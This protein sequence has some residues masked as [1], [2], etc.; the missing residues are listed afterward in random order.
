MPA[1]KVPAGLPPDRV[2]VYND[3]YDL[4]GQD[5]AD[6]FA[7]SQGVTVT[8]TPAPVTPVTPPAPAPVNLQIVTSPSGRPTVMPAGTTPPVVEIPE[9]RVQLQERPGIEALR[10]S[11]DEIA[12]GAIKARTI[13][14]QKRGMVYDDARKEAEEYVAKAREAPRTIE[15]R[16]QKVP[17]YS[18]L[19]VRGQEL[20]PKLSAG[21]TVLES[22]KPQV[23]ET[24]EQ[25]E[26]RRRFERAKRDAKTRIESEAQAAGKNYDDYVKDLLVGNAVRAGQIAEQQAMEK[27]ASEV[28]MKDIN[29]IKAQ[30]D[31]PYYAALDE[32]KGVPP[33]EVVSRWATNT[34]RGLTQEE[35]YGRLVETRGAATLRNIGGLSRIAVRG[36]EEYLVEPLV[37]GIVAATDPNVSYSD[38]TKMEE[39]AIKAGGGVAVKRGV[40]GVGE[41]AKVETGSFIKDVAQEV[42]TGRSAIDDYLDAGAP[43]GVATIMGL[44]TEFAIPATPIGVVTDVL[45][46]FGAVGRAIPGVARGAEA[47][48]ATRPIAATRRF[49]DALTNIPEAV[50][51]SRFEKELG[52]QG[53]RIGMNVSR[54]M[55]SPGW[56]KTTSEL[57]DMRTTIATKITDELVAAKEIE[58]FIRKGNA[59]VLNKML[60]EGISGDAG[61]LATFADDVAME[62]GVKLDELD[63]YLT[64]INKAETQGRELSGLQKTLWSRITDASKKVAGRN[65]A[66]LASKETPD[67][68]RNTWAALKGVDPGNYQNAGIKA[69]VAE[70]LEKVP[71][72]QYAFVTPRIAVKKSIINTKEFQDK[73]ADA[74]FASESIREVEFAVEKAIRESYKTAGDIAEP[75][76]VTVPRAEGLLPT[77]PRG[78]LE[79][80]ATPEAR[81]LPVLE[82]AQDVRDTVRAILAEMTSPAGNKRVADTF[83]GSSFIGGTQ[84]TLDTAL[85]ARVPVQMRDFIVA[86]KSEIDSLGVITTRG[87]G[88]LQIQN[89]IIKAINENPDGLNGV[90]LERMSNNIDRLGKSEDVALPMSVNT[91]SAQEAVETIVRNFF[92]E[93]NIASLSVTNAN[94]IIKS[95]VKDAVRNGQAPLDATINAIRLVREQIPELAKAGRRGT[96]LARGQDD[97]VSACLDY[98][99]KEEAKVIFKN[100]FENSYYEL[101]QASNARV[102]TIQSKV[103][104][105]MFN[106][107]RQE[108]P[109]FGADFK[110]AA[111]KAIREGKKPEFPDV[112]KE[113]MRRVD[114]FNSVD[115]NQVEMINFVQETM[116]NIIVDASIDPAALSRFKGLGPRTRKFLQLVN[117]AYGPEYATAYLDAFFDVIKN[118][119]QGILSFLEKYKIVR[120]VDENDVVT[121]INNQLS[122]P[123]PESA[124]KIIEEFIGPIS[125]LTKNT[126]VLSD[127]L[128]AI[129]RSTKSG[130]SETVSSIVRSVFDTVRGLSVGGLTTGILL[131]N[132][133]FFSLNYLG[134]PFI[135]ALTSPGLAMR[136]MASELGTIGINIGDLGAT[137]VHFVRKAA[138][139]NP[140]S[141]A[142]TSR[143]GIPYT[144]RQLN[145]YMNENY[146]GMT[147]ETFAFANKFGEDVRLEIGVN[148]A[149][150]PVR[151]MDASRD[152]VQRLL[153]V[154]GTN[155]WTKWASTVDTNWRQQVFLGALKAG[156]NAEGARRVASNAVLDYGRIPDSMRTVA[157]RYMTFFSWFAVSNAEVF[158]ALFRPRAA[159]NISKMIRGQRELHKGFGDWTYET[160]MTKKRFFAVDIGNYDD[161][162]AFYV[163]PEN[164]VVGPLI[165]QVSLV[166]GL[167]S[168]MESAA[169]GGEPL[170]PAL[171][172]AGEQL[173]QAVVEKSFTPFL[174]YLSDVGILGETGAKSKVVPARQIAFHQKMDEVF[175]GWFG[176]W[177]SDNNITT[178]PLDE[179]RLGDPTFFGQQYQYASDEARKRAA[180]YDYMYVM[181]GLNRLISD[182]QQAGMTIAP[183]TGMEAKRF[184]ATGPLGIPLNILQYFSAGTLSKGTTEH[185]E[186]RKAIL[187]TN[188]ELNKI[189]EQK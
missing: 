56:W 21:E 172:G 140:D 13:A 97:I 130:V 81:R 2:Q 82:A 151:M 135:M 75:V 178:L 166:N 41:R 48:A 137:N 107:M 106:W 144:Y 126:G 14:N 11:Q 139:T 98:L 38:L 110:E 127:N 146:F 108:R 31:A 71:S 155:L 73:M 92:G 51:L 134:A 69:A 61:Y 162:P 12:E 147:A 118:E 185:E 57:S 89:P 20:L 52:G 95:A 183:P 28:L 29:D 100:N 99:I 153:N 159:S 19:A 148:H 83:A 15:F 26:G 167:L 128:T 171:A 168:I 17:G 10:L 169:P 131:P 66:K 90:L 154:T 42:A 23:L 64:S 76:A 50:R 30:L 180:F 174:G 36:A 46:A 77:A 187:N 142:F 113:F 189:S 25:A 24:A 70:V 101:I 176:E 157:R 96:G 78:G 120:P 117:E 35:R 109:P 186:V 88:G 5:A 184:E 6:E 53:E 58:D 188:R 37:K 55:K 68:V 63:F 160:D 129:N 179:R 150:T 86:T 122:L 121:F 93:T 22:I 114:E 33:N 182:M 94:S 65:A 43:A 74:A 34:L 152:K 143:T 54:K 132:P 125:D 103:R 79:R 47:L 44:A 165:D 59:R 27:G 138:Q 136:A 149:G 161:L 116:K 145:D 4:L 123:I 141:I 133:K 39:D 158:S 67:I 164:P 112:V 45:P 7:A 104:E 87:A 60:R 163:G 156:E 9:P 85:N 173:A 177:M 16:G 49:T 170:G 181:V 40:K 102:K 8:P 124:K 62:M 84:R 91:A 18:E 115:A 80:M 105:T 175:P 72:S 1:P 32:L 119:S 3:L 111:T